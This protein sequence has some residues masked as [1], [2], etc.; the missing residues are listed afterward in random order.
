MTTMR[1]TLEKMPKWLICVPLVVQWLWRGLRDGSLTLPS[2]A[3]PNITA[4]GLVGEGKIE[5]FKQMGPLGRAAAAPYLGLRIV[6]ELSE[7]DVARALEA[8]DIAFPVVA[9]PAPGLCG[10]GVRK[11]A[12]PDALRS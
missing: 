8:A 4:G 10:Y 6:D 11:L 2:A 3:N 1:S 9:K 12:D 5:Y 7:A